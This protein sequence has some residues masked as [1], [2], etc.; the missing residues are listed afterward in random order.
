MKLVILDHYDS[1]TYNLY[2]YFCELG[3]KP[4]VLKTDFTN[5]FEV[6]KKV[7][8]EFDYLVFSPGFGNP[9]DLSFLKKVLR[10]FAPKKY[11]LG[12][13]LGHQLLA[14]S[15][16]GN[17]K[18]LNTPMHAKQVT[19]KTKANDLTKHLDSSFKVALY[20]SLYVSNV[21]DLKMLGYSMID[22][23]KIPMIIKHKKFQVYGIQFHPESILS[24]N[25]LAILKNFLELKNH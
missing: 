15:F 2:Y 18:E 7:L 6:A 21:G 24:H 10:Y 3:I 9:K 12:V 11:I 1:F 13:C 5:D 22:K 4:V 25:G 16:N 20:N 19:L 8:D 17:V 14:L 23:E